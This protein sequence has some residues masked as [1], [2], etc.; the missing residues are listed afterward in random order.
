M[1]DLKEI[2]DAILQLDSE[3]PNH[4][5]VD[6]SPKLEAIRFILKD[7]TIT[8]EQVTEALK[9]DTT[10][11]PTVIEP[12]INTQIVWDDSVEQKSEEGV[13]IS[14]VEQA[15]RLL[16]NRD[17]LD[18]EIAELTKYR[19]EVN[20][21]LEEI[22]SQLEKENTMTLHDTLSAFLDAQHVERLAGLE[23]QPNYTKAPP[24]RF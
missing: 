24:G 3:N 7:Q 18:D 11:V 8:R 14:L 1:L 12:N 2:K 15:K 6:G 21:K 23:P 5:L 22:E 4:W 17:A 16:E 19:A 13:D 9:V 10:E 20:A